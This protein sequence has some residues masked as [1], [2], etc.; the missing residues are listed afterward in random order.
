MADHE[1]HLPISTP[2]PVTRPAWCPGCDAM[3]TPHHHTGACPWCDT[4]GAKLGHTMQRA[5]EA[6]ALQHLTEPRRLV[7]A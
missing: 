2:A 7:S 5:L 4:P 3:T 6:T 1:E